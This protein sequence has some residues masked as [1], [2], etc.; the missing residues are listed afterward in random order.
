[1]PAYSGSAIVLRVMK[2]FCSAP[3]CCLRGSGVVRKKW[4]VQYGGTSRRTDRPASEP[5]FHNE[6]ILGGIGLNISR[7]FQRM[8]KRGAAVAEQQDLSD[9]V[10]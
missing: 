3:G 10:L 2:E 8:P 1:M 5:V 7:C 6:R 9:L 4:P